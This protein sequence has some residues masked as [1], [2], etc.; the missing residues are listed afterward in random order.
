MDWQFI[1]KLNKSEGSCKAGKQ[2]DSLCSRSL[3]VEQPKKHVLKK[4]RKLLSSFYKMWKNR[5]N[6]EMSVLITCNYHSVPLNALIAAPH[7]HHHHL[8]LDPF[9]LPKQILPIKHNSV[10][11]PVNTTLL[12]MSVSLT[13]L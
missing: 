1:P 9:H 8:F 3:S 12:S 6:L 10:Q 2:V 7:H 5:H 4:C 11:P 13:T